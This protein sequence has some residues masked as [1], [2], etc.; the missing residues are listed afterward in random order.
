M[1]T[2]LLLALLVSACADAAPT[3]SQ[4]NDPTGVALGWDPPVVGQTFDTPPTRPPG[5]FPN[6][7]DRDTA[8]A[9]PWGA[10]L[11][12]CMPDGVAGCCWSEIGECGV[13]SCHWDG[14]WHTLSGY[15]GKRGSPE[16]CACAEQYGTADRC[17]YDI[18]NTWY[19]VSPARYAET[20]CEP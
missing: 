8:D 11:L 19:N 4:S 6:C 2:A 12:A 1:R 14:A 13:F 17:G 20:G 7:V 10:S 9:S 3:L 5:D 18:P 16:G 15:A